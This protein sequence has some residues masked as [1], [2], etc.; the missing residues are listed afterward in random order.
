MECLEYT[1]TW[2]ESSNLNPLDFS[3]CN[4]LKNSV[5]KKKKRWINI[6]QGG[7]KINL[8]I[9]IQKLFKEEIVHETFKKLCFFTKNRIIMQIFATGMI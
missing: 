6:P 3:V 7:M 4:H 8:K 2:S 9:E 1:N 5:Y